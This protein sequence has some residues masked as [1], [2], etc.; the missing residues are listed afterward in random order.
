MGSLKRCPGCGGKG[1]IENPPQHLL[2]EYDICSRCQGHGK[3]CGGCDWALEC[4]ECGDDAPTGDL[5]A[6]ED[7]KKAWNL[8]TDD[9][10]I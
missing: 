6:L 10:A 2:R 1:E 4:C 5:P 9:Q 7:I 3:V 8:E